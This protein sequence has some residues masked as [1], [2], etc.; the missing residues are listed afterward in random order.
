MY[1]VGDP[2]TSYDAA[3]LYPFKLRQRDHHPITMEFIVDA[4]TAN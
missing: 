1:T 4:M 2:N 3:V